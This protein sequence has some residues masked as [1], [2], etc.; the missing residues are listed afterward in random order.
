MWETAVCGT[1][2]AATAKAIKYVSDKIGVDKVSM[3]SD[4]D[5]AIE[6]IYDINGFKEVVNEL[7]KLSFSRTDIEKIMGGNIRDFLLRNLP[8]E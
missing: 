6:A 3:G 4:F 2:A 1:D 7:I 5:G 8:K